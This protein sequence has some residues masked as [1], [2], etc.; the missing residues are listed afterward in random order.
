M[1]LELITLL[2]IKR[3]E[4]IYELILPTAAGEIAVFPGHEPLVTL[5]VPGVAAIRHNKGDAD[6]KLEYFAI[7]GGIIEISQEKVRVLVDEADHSDDITESEAKAAL[8]RA[9]KLR[10]SAKTQIEIDKAEQLIGRQQ[11]RLHVADLHR[12]RRR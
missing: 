6:E 11:V 2:G 4:Q 9:V 5:A 10:E 3:D 8:E 1:H 7:S 12:R